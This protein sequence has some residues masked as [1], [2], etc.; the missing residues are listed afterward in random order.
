MGREI[1]GVRLEAKLGAGGMA[2]VYAGVDVERRGVRCAVKVLSVAS[3]EAYLE[4]FRREAQIGAAL[5]HSSLVRVHR[6]G[7]SGDFLFMVMDLVEGED[8]AHVLD[9]EGP[10]AWP[11][12]A[13]LGRDI[14]RALGELHARGVVHRDLKPANVLL[15]GRGGLRLADF[16][17]ARWREAPSDLRTEAPLTA[18][19]DAFGT[20]IYMA[21][22]QFVDAKTTGPPADFYALGVILFEALTGQPPF[23]ASRPHALAQL[24]RDVPPPSLDA[25]AA[26]APPALR[27]VIE[28]LLEKEPEARPAAAV[29][30]A[31]RLAGL[32]AGADTAPI[33][34]E[35]PPGSTHRLW[36]GGSGDSSTLPPRARPSRAGVAAAVAV[37][38]TLGVGAL[39]WAV[40]GL[41][42]HLATAE[43]RASYQAL[44]AAL[45]ELDVAP[46]AF[47]GALDRYGRD[48][49]QRGLLRDE[50]AALRERPH[51]LRANVYLVAT[52]G[53]AM[54]H[55][56][57]GRYAIGHRGPPVEGVDLSPAR[58]ARLPGFLIDRAEVSNRR[59]E[60]FWAEWTAAGAA[61]R[62]GNDD[63]D[64]R[65]PEAGR[66]LSDAP[67]GPA[68]G[69]SPYDAL[70][71]ARFHGR[72]LPHEDE[73]EVAASWDPQG[74]QARPYPWGASEPSRDNP[75][76]ANLSLAEYGQVNEAGEFVTTCAPSGTFELDRS[77]FGL[78]DVAG[79]AAEWCQGDTSLPGD[80]PLRGGSID[81]DGGRGALLAVRRVLA[82]E[83]VRLAGFRTVVPFEP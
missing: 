31:D 63:L 12:V 21:P 44:V 73:W 29:E 55:V 5:D 17:L 83:R 19:G 70:E 59:Y 10:L 13:A 52:D 38:A 50:V 61:H 33:P 51:H 45:S 54:I 1:G 47:L 16:G 49:G 46:A 76:L 43:E 66:R 18:T 48:F 2:S 77:G 6:S 25:Q 79:N 11:Q 9:R 53:A 56:P 8:L 81:T 32:V 7:V 22:E 78:L 67:D 34:L 37:A 72:R 14:A 4:R 68:V 82:P 60:R 74:N 20:P 35:P 41:R 62:C 39:V 28:D 36:R 27:A 71:Y 40:P 57:G 75:Y 3:H 65:L 26:D 58:T 30:V 64:H 15:D 24:H 80:Q 69:L 23:R 42:V